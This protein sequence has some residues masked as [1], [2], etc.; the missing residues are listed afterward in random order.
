MKD[1]GFEPD[2]PLDGRDKR[3]KTE[4]LRSW[5]DEALRRDAEL[6]AEA[7]SARPAA[8]VFREARRLLD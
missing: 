6:D 7:A 5:A 2:G 8:E 3:S 4:I 1:D